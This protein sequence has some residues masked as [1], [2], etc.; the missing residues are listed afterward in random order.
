VA[1]GATAR[2]AGDLAPLEPTL[3][4]TLGDLPLRVTFGVISLLT[5][6]RPGPPLRQLAAESRGHGPPMLLVATGSIPQEI[7][8][9]RRYASAAHAELWTLPETAHT[10]GIYDAPGY[11]HRVVGFLDRALHAGH[12]EPGSAP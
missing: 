6:T 7:P 5:G 10:R 2:S 1:D 12:V 9:S 11:E 3:A 8:L 4:D